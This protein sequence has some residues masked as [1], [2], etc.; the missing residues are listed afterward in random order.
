[1]NDQQAVEFQ[2]HTGS[3]KSENIRLR[4]FLIIWFQ[5]HTGSIKRKTMLTFM[6]PIK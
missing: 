2:F 4:E 3:I 5:F 1:M 6:I